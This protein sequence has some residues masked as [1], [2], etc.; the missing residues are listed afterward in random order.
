VNG[1]QHVGDSAGVSVLETALA[2]VVVGKK[3]G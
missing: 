2:L 1:E 3:G